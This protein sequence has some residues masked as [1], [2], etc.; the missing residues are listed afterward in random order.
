MGWIGP[1]ILIILAVLTCY[2]LKWDI[3]LV[4]YRPLAFKSLLRHM[5]GL[6]ASQ[7]KIET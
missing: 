2:D 4:P 5:G 7:I 6:H 3:N 1:V